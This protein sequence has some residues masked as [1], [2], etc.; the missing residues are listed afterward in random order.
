MEDVTLSPSMSTDVDT[1]EPPE[2]LREFV[3][4]LYQLNEA[5]KKYG[6][7]VCDLLAEWAKAKHGANLYG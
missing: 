3:L 4:D 1:Y 6:L 2:G 7:S 5:C